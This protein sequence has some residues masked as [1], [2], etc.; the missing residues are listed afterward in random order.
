[1]MNKDA[2]RTDLQCTNVTKAIFEEAAQ[3]LEDDDVNVSTLP[4]AW[5][6]NP[7]KTE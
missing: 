7:T 1:M 4:S 5:V 2:Q 3:T 6:K